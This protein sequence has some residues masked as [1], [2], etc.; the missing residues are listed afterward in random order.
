[1]Q[2]AIDLVELARGIARIASTTTDPETARALLELIEEL[3]QAAGLPPGK[4]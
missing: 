4:P 2:D 3:M 1:M